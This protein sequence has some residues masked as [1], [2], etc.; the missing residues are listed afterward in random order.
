M[1][2]SLAA[3]VEETWRRH[4]YNEDYFP[5]LAAEAL[6]ASNLDR[7]EP[8]EVLEYAAGPDELPPA[9]DP[10]GSFGQPPITVYANERFIVDVYFW[11]DG[12]TSVHDHAFS[13]AFRVL[14]GSSIQARYQ[15]DVRRRVSASMQV[16]DL[17]CLGVDLLGSGAV[18]PIVAGSRCIH[19][20]FHL[21]RPSVSVVVRTRRE[22]EHYPQHEYLRPHLRMA[23]GGHVSRDRTRVGALRALRETNPAAF[24][25]RVAEAVRSCTAQSAFAVCRAFCEDSELR[26]T[27]AAAL[28]EGHA[29]VAEPLGAVLVELSGDAFLKRKRAA[30][31]DLDARF[32]LGVALVAPDRPSIRGLIEE[33]YGVGAL[34]LLPTRVLSLIEPEFGPVNNALLEAFLFEEGEDALERTRRGLFCQKPGDIEAAREFV[35]RARTHPLL[36]RVGGCSRS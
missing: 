9:F 5:T 25:V 36:S 8:G 26:D 31:R 6:S 30:T 1:F 11:F 19:S 14:G 20:L 34:K 28:L 27:L 33:R 24:L 15:F 21:D 4:D 23:I 12:T 16:G 2:A 22:P 10:E 35:T 32:L 3:Q 13:G 17:R 18:C 7:I 29:T